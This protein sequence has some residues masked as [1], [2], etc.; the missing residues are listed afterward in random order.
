MCVYILYYYWCVFRAAVGFSWPKKTLRAAAQHGPSRNSSRVRDVNPRFT[1]SRRRGEYHSCGVIE[2]TAS[3][4]FIIF[5]LREWGDTSSH[6]TVQC[7]AAHS[8]EHTSWWT[9]FSI[10]II[11]W[12]RW[13]LKQFFFFFA[14][15]W[16]IHTFFFSPFPYFPCS[17]TI[18]LFVTSQ[19]ATTPLYCWRLFPHML[20]AQ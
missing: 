1:S 10:M 5:V 6:H 8:W 12:L 13:V 20:K 4:W 3:V 15:V 7:N 17:P 2:G 16:E 11:V 19:R 18:G 14:I 9:L